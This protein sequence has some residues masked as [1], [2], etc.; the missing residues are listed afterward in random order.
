MAVSFSY[1]GAAQLNDYKYIVIPKKFDGFKKENEHQ[2]STLIKHLFSEKGFHTVYDDALPADLNSNRCLGLFV[3]L[4]DQSSMFSTKTTIRLKDCNGAEIMATQ[5][6]KS[7]IKEYKGAYNEAI[8]DAFRSFNGI[9]YA[10]TP[11]SQGNTSVT[12]NFKDDVKK[13]EEEIPEAPKNVVPEAVV[14]QQATR[15]VQRYKDRTPVP[16]DLKEVE[17][18]EP[19]T[20]APVS[21][22]NVLYAQEIPNGFQLVDS[23]PKVVLKIYKSGMADQYIASSEDRNGVVY[24]KDG[25]WYFEYYTNGERTV[26]ELNIKF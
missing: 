26:E 8:R 6:G 12:L 15:E 14:Q 7:R 17:A 18:T 9:N 23:T 16:T 19:V 20:D 3:V 22:A 10:Y 2:T 25:K 4:D 13:L 11:K 1:F 21:T 24:T 5:E